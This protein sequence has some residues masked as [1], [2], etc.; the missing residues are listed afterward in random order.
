[1]QKLLEGSECTDMRSWDV[2]Y[3]K[4]SPDFHIPLSLSAGVHATTAL[5]AVPV[6]RVNLSLSP[7]CI[8]EHDCL[9]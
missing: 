6:Q 9:Y 8:V 1:M 3:Y 5:V 4:N 7:C 2:F